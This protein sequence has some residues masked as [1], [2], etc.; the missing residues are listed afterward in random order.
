M[1]LGVQ[2]GMT[3]NCAFNVCG[4]IKFSRE[5]TQS[6]SPQQVS[7]P[8]GCPGLMELPGQATR[9]PKAP[10][11][12]LSPCLSLLCTA[13]GCQLFAVGRVPSFHRDLWY[14]LGHQVA[15]DTVPGPQSLATPAESPSPDKGTCSRVWG[16]G[17]CYRQP[18]PAPRGVLGFIA[19]SLH[20][21]GPP[22]VFSVPCSP[23][24]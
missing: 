15:R 5:R 10:G 3:G 13:H 22:L 19:V 17:G 4:R 2:P 6:A 7:G 21:L 12:H 16:V 20:L 24:C 8:R 9:L 23:F 14:P 18:S 11:E 1:S